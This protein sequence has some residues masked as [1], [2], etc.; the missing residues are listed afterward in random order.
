MYISDYTILPNIFSG[1]GISRNFPQ[2]R[3][4]GGLDAGYGQF[5]WAALVVIKGPD[6]DKMCAGT[7]VHDRSIFEM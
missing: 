1:C 7:L 2:S 6:I 5:P 3:I 4:L